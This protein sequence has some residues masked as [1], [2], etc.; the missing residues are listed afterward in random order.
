[1]QQNTT[2]VEQQDNILQKFIKKYIAKFYRRYIKIW[3]NSIILFIVCMIVGFCAGITIQG[4]FNWSF[5]KNDGQFISYSSIV[6]FLLVVIYMYYRRLCKTSGDIYEIDKKSFKYLFYAVSFMFFSLYYN[7]NKK[8][9]L[10]T[11]AKNKFGIEQEQYVLILNFI[12]YFLIS[13]LIYTIVFKNYSL[14][15]FGK[16]GI[17]LEEEKTVADE[18]N[19]VINL[20]VDIIKEYSDILCELDCKMEEMYNEGFVRDDYTVEEY[21][22]FL[23]DFLSSFTLKDSNL[24]IIIISMDEFDTFAKTELSYNRFALSKIKT[25]THENK[26]Y[27]CENRIFVEY[28]TTIIQASIMIIIESITTYPWDLGLLIYSYMVALETSYSKYLV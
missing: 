21:S 11:Y 16:D 10:N 17:E 22:V 24:S 9:F 28:H 13:T 20:Y 2:P 23:D 27:T 8:F 26:V 7:I 14:K 15:K 5:Y 4:K 19:S 1:M 12:G 25:N 6:I 18:Q 3:S